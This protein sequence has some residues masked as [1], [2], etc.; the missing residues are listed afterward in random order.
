MSKTFR[1]IKKYFR[2]DNLVFA[3]SIFISFITTISSYLG[4]ITFSLSQGINIPVLCLISLLGAF[5]III[6]TALV[7]HKF[8]YYRA[9]TKYL[10]KSNDPLYRICSYLAKK[11]TRENEKRCNNI[12]INDLKIT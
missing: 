4:I 6:F 5:G 9:I 12:K 10:E 8:E 3:L 2:K 11:K 7:Y 1:F